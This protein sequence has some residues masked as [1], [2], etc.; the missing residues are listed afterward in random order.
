ML[1]K[2]YRKDFIKVD[3]VLKEQMAKLFSLPEDNLLF[4]PQHSEGFRNI[5]NKSK[6][7]A[8]V[9]FISEGTK[10]NLEL[11]SYSGRPLILDVTFDTSYLVI[12]SIDIK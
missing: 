4:L 1:Y 7:T 10:Y 5:L 12:R 6:K 11:Y 2:K 9:N 8:T 3:H